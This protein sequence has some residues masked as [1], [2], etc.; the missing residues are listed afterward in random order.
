MKVGELR[1]MLEDVGDDHLE[2]YIGH[3]PQ[4][5]I[6]LGVAGIRHPNEEREV[7]CPVHEGY[8]VGHSLNC[9]AEPDDDDDGGNDLD[10]HRIVWIVASDGSPYE[11]SPYAPRWLW[12]E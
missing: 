12:G 8:L 4:Y 5:P 7:E 1:E 9:S 3:Q 10:D 6:C 2:V 11:R